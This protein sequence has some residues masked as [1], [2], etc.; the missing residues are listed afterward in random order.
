MSDSICLTNFLIYFYL[1][2]LFVDEV[3]WIY[4]VENH[5]FCDEKQYCSFLPNLFVSFTSF[6]VL[7]MTANIY[8]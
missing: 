2:L 7:T 3:D 5:I 8:V 6:T 1:F 4:Y